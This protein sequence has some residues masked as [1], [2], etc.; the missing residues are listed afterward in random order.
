M[1]RNHQLEN[2]ISEYR[3]IMMAKGHLFRLGLRLKV[4]K[5]KLIKLENIL[6]KEYQDLERFKETSVRN[7]LVSF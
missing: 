2:L 1:D 5:K 4:E 3:S 6:E 7:L